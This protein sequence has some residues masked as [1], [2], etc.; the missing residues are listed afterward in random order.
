MF[1]TFKIKDTLIGVYN[2]ILSLFLF[3]YAFKKL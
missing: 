1:D 2:K 3:T